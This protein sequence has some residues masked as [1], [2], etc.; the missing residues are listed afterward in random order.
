MSDY[1]HLTETLYGNFLAALLDAER[2]AGD[3]IA[4]T[5]AADAL[6]IPV[7]EVEFLARRMVV[8][9]RACIDAEELTRRTPPNQRA[10]QRAPSQPWKGQS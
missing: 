1:D 8:L 6:L 10:D 5:A 9:L 3:L 7:D 4:K 2:V